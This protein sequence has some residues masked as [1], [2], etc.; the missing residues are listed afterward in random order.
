M[1]ALVLCVPLA[2]AWA[3]QAPV[4][5]RPVATVRQVHDL[6]IS[7]ASDAV[8]RAGGDTPTTDGA[9]LDARN[10]AMLLAE[11]GNLLMLGSR[12]RDT[13]A[14]MRMSRAL[15]DAA[16]SA[17]TAAERKDANAL[18]AAGDAITVTCESCHRPYRDNGRQMGSPR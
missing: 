9:W 10:Q 13:A 17:A 7:P 6:L 8:F 15:V 2:S 1:V 3:Q 14:W 12:A 18:A 4:T 5:V 16:A 11:S